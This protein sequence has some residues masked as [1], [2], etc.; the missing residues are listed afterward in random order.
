LAGL[1]N[2]ALEPLIG[3]LI[4]GVVKKNAGVQSGADTTYAQT[5]A[6]GLVDELN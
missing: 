5:N 3:T 6:Q 2:T 4:T 1:R